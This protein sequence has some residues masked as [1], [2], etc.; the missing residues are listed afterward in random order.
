[1]I[2]SFTIMLFII[3]YYASTRAAVRAWVE[4]SASPTHPLSHHTTLA[5]RSVPSSSCP[6]TYPSFVC[7]K[8]IRLFR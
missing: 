8:Y 5:W 3:L 2:K 1:M 7:N 4:V 6:L